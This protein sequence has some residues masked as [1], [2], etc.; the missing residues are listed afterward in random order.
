MADIK[1]IILKYALYNAY[2]HEGKANK[3]SV[4]GKIIAEKPEVKKDLKSIMPIV[5]STIKEV[6]EMSLEEQKH[7][8]DSDFPEVFEKKEENKSIFDKLN[9]SLKNIDLSKL[10]V[11]KVKYVVRTA[12]PPSPEKYLHIGHAKAVLLNYLLAKEYNGEFYLRFE[13]TNPRLV[14]EIYYDAIVEDLKWLGVIPDKIQYASDYMQLYYSFAE[15]LI[16]K[17]KAYVCTCPQEVIRENRLKGKA[18]SCRDRSVEENMKLWKEMHDSA[19]YVLRL[20]IDMKHKNS[21]M[22]DPIAFRVIDEKHPRVNAR[23]WPAYDFEN[24]VMDGYFVVTHRLRSKEFELRNELQRWI[25]K[26]LNLYQTEIFELARFEL[27]GVETSGRKI[28][29]LIENGDL[30]GWD[31]PSLATLRALKRRGFLP[32]TIRDFVI[33]T[34]ISKNEAKLTWNDLI[35]INRRYLDKIAKRFF[36]IADPV[37]IT[38]E[39]SPS[40]KV[41]LNAYPKNVDKKE[42][43]VFECTSEYYVSKKDYD[44]MLKN[45]GMYRLMDNLNFEVKDGKFYFVS[46]SHDDFKNNNGKRI[47]HWLPQSVLNVFVL[48]PGKN[49]T[50]KIKAI[51][52]TNVS[53]VKVGEIVQFERFGFCRYDGNST[54]VYT[55][56]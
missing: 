12:F 6:N 24:A 43:R 15:E 19:G 55:H 3:G 38:I 21:T 25:Q 34:G 29:A 16:K 50:S 17:G 48:I 23:V 4:I 53:N 22:R 45:P 2:L 11:A 13:D 46:E 40:R 36:L 7:I 39:G 10:N 54:F 20:K 9:I 37:K 51:A 42:D 52:E 1:K 5:D 44:E 18:C 26:E 33:S 47:I 56:K 14:N 8:L 28:R 27:E 30:D 35:L 31:D 49:K 32:E 41:V